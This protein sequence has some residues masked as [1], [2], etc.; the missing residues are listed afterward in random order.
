[1]T[2]GGSEGEEVGWP[3]SGGD[4]AGGE[5][6]MVAMLGYVEDKMAKVGRLARRQSRGCDKVKGVVEV[7]GDGRR[8]QSRKK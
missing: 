3:V 8:W 6:V 4:I 5:A 1:M 7:G 2:R